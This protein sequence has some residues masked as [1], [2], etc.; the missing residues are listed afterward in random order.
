MAES[1]EICVDRLLQVQSE[2]PRCA[3]IH[4]IPPPPSLLLSSLA[5]ML[6]EVAVRIFGV[7]ISERKR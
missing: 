2:R 7:V 4:F 3:H 6:H 1:G 5:R